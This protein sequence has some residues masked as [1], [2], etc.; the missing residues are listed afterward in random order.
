M[1][2]STDPTILRILD[3]AIQLTR[4]EREFKI[5]LEVK[6][7]N[8]HAEFEAVLEYYFDVKTLG[9]ISDD[10]FNRAVLICYKFIY[11]LRDS[12]RSTY[13]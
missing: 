13:H 11:T 12:G 1:S 4:P 6:K 5:E 10:D 3:G 7:Y 9:D 2:A 8:A